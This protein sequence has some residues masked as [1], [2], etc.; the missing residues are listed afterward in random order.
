MKA[1]FSTILFVLGSGACAAAGAAAT[2]YTADGTAAYWIN[3]LRASCLPAEGGGGGGGESA[4]AEVGAG[5]S[6]SSGCGGDDILFSKITLT[7]A[8]AAA[9]DYSHFYDSPL[10]G[11][12]CS[13][14]LQGSD[15]EKIIGIPPFWGALGRAL[16]QSFSFLGISIR[17]CS[18][19]RTGGGGGGAAPSFAPLPR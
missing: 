2:D 10:D 18:A 8:S 9:P 15:G 19:L 5:C 7:G 12:V 1:C 17:C 6:L 3:R 14:L 11:Y 16:A 4:S 13:D